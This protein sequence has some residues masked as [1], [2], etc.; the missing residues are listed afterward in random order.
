MRT[1]FFSVAIVSVFLQAAA[2]TV[3]RHI[4]SDEFTQADSDVLIA[5]AQ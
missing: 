1:A 4:V 2:V 5:Q 3:D